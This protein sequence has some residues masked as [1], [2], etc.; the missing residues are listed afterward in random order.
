[1]N[2]KIYV[3]EQLAW[4]YDG[5]FN[6]SSNADITSYILGYI[7]NKCFGIV[8]CIIPIRYK[9]DSRGGFSLLINIFGPTKGYKVRI[10][11]VYFEKAGI[12]NI[13][14]YSKDYKKVCYTNLSKVYVLPPGKVNIFRIPCDI[15][16]DNIKDIIVETTCGV[17]D[18][19]SNHPVRKK[20]LWCLE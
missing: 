5:F 19:L 13:T 6:E 12:K 18:K 11:N 17:K 14:I 3:G 8:P 7:N 1:M 4:K 9:A 10:K 2:P 20:I 15:L 16:C